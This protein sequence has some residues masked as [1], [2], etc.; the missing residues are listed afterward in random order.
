MNPQISIPCAIA[1]IAFFVA[2][3]KS[4]LI[5]LIY[6]RSLDLG[7]RT[8]VTERLSQLGKNKV[9]DYENFRI[10]QMVFVAVGFAL[11]TV[12]FFL[13]FLSW[14]IYCLLVVLVPVIT[15]LCTE[16]NLTLRCENR[17]KNIES[18]FPAI[19]EML[20]LAVGAGESPA[21]A[22]KR[23][24]NR[25][26]GHLAR[27]F[28]RVVLEIENGIPF[29]TALDEMSRRV[30]SDALR[31]FADSL[32]ISISRGTSLVETLTHSA[33][34]SRNQER[35]RLLTA[36]GKSE[37]SMMIPVVFLI[38]PISILFALYPSLTNLNLFS[39]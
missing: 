1:V 38:L 21:S 6:R 19:V 10:T 30:N 5:H 15:F 20:T 8:S 31:R 3:E 11:S 34:E 9:S 23:I 14:T 39:S 18:E 24:S 16:R 35:V 4:N 27:E 36:A 26:H 17:R 7:N 37:I 33:N 2:D 29:T 12:A 28:S 22:L 13:A 25:A 32:I